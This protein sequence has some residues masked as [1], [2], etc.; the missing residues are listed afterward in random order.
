MNDKAFLTRQQLTDALMTHEGWNA[1]A[2]EE[3]ADKILASGNQHPTAVPPFQDLHGAEIV[4]TMAFH[5]DTLLTE[6]T[7]K[8]ANTIITMTFCPDAA[9]EEISA[10]ISG[11][12]VLADELFDKANAQLEAT[13]MKGDPDA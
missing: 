6:L 3:L 1:D 8:S 4:G 11:W 13:I 12:P 10:M 7:A 2:A 9:P 5:P